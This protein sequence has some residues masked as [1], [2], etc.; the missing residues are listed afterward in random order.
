RRN[1]PVVGARNVEGLHA[2]FAI[3]LDD[4]LL[5]K[6]RLLPEFP[7]SKQ[8]GGGKTYLVRDPS[9]YPNAEILSRI[10]KEHCYTEV[11]GKEG[12]FFV[13]QMKI[14]PRT[15]DATLRSPPAGPG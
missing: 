15:C 3:M 11:V 1:L 7:E 9:A 4:A 12:S 13:R 10:L 8:H 6:K 2:A 14:L 5:V